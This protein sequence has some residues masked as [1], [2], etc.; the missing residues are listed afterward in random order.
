LTMNR[1]GKVYIIGGGPGDPELITLRGA[2]CMA[3]ADLVVYDYLVSEE[4]LDYAPREARLV[5]AGKRS[6]QHTLTQDEINSLLVDEARKGQV[7]ARLKGGDPFIFGRGGE[8]ALALAR[9]GVSFEVVPGISSAVAVPCYAGIPLTQ[10]EYT[11]TVAFITGHED[12]TKSESRLHWKQLAALE[13]LVFLMGVKNLALI[14]EQLIRHGKD[15]ATPAAL[16]RR[17]TT[18]D[19]ETL[20]DS[21]G[22][23]AESAKARGMTPPAVFVVGEVAA[24][25]KELSWYENKPLFGKG[26]VVTRPRGQADEF[27]ELLRAEGARVI[28]FPVITVEPLEN[29]APLDEALDRIG[30]YRWLIFTSANSVRFF[31]QRL[32]DR[33]MDIRDMKGPRIACIGPATAQAIRRKGLN[34]DIVPDD[35]ISEGVIKAFDGIDLD[36]AKV[37]LPRAETARDVIPEGLAARGA[38]VEV[39]PL[40]RTTGSG[41]EGAELIAMM[42][43]GRVDV[44]T[45][46]SP[47]TVKHCLKMIG[48]VESIPDAVKI[49]C[50]GPVTAEAAK[51]AGLGVDI[52]QGPYDMKG[53]VSA[54]VKGMTH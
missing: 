20:V 49:A 30:E 6:G 21:L 26:I 54:I 9:A 17:G 40:Y 24:L 43:E 14:T 11:S 16:I 36:G 53:F 52:M 39:V 8:E 51:K 3:E 41:R 23:I 22:S 34:V 10:R 4:L 29:T 2:R 45:F 19:Q 15:P 46:T 47:S 31:F 7:V 38:S 33:S 35:Y 13:T 1:E 32:R 5:Y 50:I 28:L 42:E 18:P 37:L 25:R 44:L 48:G 27:A 12:P